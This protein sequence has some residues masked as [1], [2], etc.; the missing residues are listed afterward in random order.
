MDNKGEWDALPWYQKKLMHLY[1]CPDY[2]LNLSM[3]PTIAYAGEI[4]PQQQ[5]G[6]VMA[7]AM[8]DLG[9]KLERIYGPNTAHKYEKNAKKDLDARLDA[10]AQKGRDATPREIHFETWT[11]RYNRM[12]WLTIDGMERHWDSA[13]IDAT[14]SGEGAVDATTRNITGLTIHLPTAIELKIDGQSLSIPAGDAAKGASIV[15]SNGKWTLGAPSSAT[16][17]KRHALQGPIDDAFLD[18]FVIVRPTGQPLN[19]KVGKWAAS[20]A[21]YATNEWRKIFRGV[22]PTKNDDQVTGEDIANSDLVLFGD[23]SSN[24]VLKKIADRLPIKWTKEAITLGERTFT[25]D[26]HALIAI[27]PNPLNPQRYVVLNSGFTFRQADHKTN[28]RQ[29]AKL[30]DYAVV[31]LNTPADD[32]VPGAIPAAGF[33]DEAWQL[34][35]DDGQGVK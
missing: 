29:I 34:Q 13:R 8:A 30:P 35:K 1:D 21:D 16:L 9:L 27:Y 33:F 25:A 12:R 10:Y 11:L 24:V 32:K 28:S 17:R 22:A 7:K 19:E 14:R 31:D 18:S 23:P 15:K 5:S 6:D 4:D 3:C 26:R 20:E 2:A